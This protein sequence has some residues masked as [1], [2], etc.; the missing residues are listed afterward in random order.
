MKLGRNDKCYCGSNK[1][2]KKCHMD[3]DQVPKEVIS[4]FEEES[5]NQEKLRRM[6]IYINYVSPI[7]FQ[8]RKVWAIGSKV[9]SNRNPNETF[10]DFIQFYLQETL[11]FTWIEDQKLLP[12]P[13][14]HF[15]VKG[16]IELEKFQE[17][18]L[19]NGVPDE[20]GI[21]TSKPNGWV[22]SLITLAFDVATLKHVS[23]LPNNIIS[24]L[25]IP[26]EYQGARYEIMIASIFVRLGFNIKW[27]EEDRSTKHCEFIA[28]HIET[29]TEI[30]VEVKSR[31]RSGILHTPGKDKGIKNYK[32]DVQRLIN[33]AKKKTEYGKIPFFI[34]IDMNS[35]F[36]E[37]EDFTNVPWIKDILNKQKLSKTFTKE[38]PSPWNATYFTNF[39]PH[40]N[41][42]SD[43]DPG[44]ML[45]SMPQFI[46]NE[47]PNTKL[48]LSI[49]NALK[50]YGEIPNID[51]S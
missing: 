27:L 3:S 34:F 4:F 21:I 33:N 45:Q 41:A 19:H 46:L 43:A 7:L 25:K 12:A 16:I 22:K 20:N 26:R 29:N 32:G 17:K 47:I 30:G 44:Q 8:G 42:D 36:T 9:Y 39:S 37:P 28:T 23:S 35:P 40:Y 13:D 6:G 1:K 51:V 11:D 49:L 31:H 14:Q 5:K 15:L 24:R 18:T 50:H 10:H 2:Y 38:N 48:Y